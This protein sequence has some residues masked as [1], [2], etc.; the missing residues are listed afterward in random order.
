MR[1]HIDGLTPE[2]EEILNIGGEM[3]L[4]K[5]IVALCDRPPFELTHTR[6]M[7]AWLDERAAAMGND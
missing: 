2:S 5:A 7:I 3:A 1:L 4:R 6:A